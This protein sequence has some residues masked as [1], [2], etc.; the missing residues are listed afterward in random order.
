M[1]KCLFVLSIDTEE[2]WDWNGP[3]PNEVISVENVAE[4]PEF[5]NGLNKLGIIPTYLLD[6]AVIDNSKARNTL[7]T[8]QQQNPE[9]EFGAHLHPWVTPPI[10]N[11][12]AEADS[13][14]VNL[15]IETVQLQIDTLKNSIT[16]YFGR[17]PTSFRSGRWGINNQI[18]SYLLDSGFTVDSSVYPFYKNKWFNYQ[19]TS[20]FPGFLYPKENREESIFELPVT[21]GFNYKNFGFANAAQQFLEKKPMNYLRPIGL[22]WQ[23][24]L[25]RKIYLSPELS[26]ATDMI[27]LCKKAMAINAPVIHMN[28]HS[29][30]LLPG[31]TSYVKDRNEKLKMIEKI[32]R[33]VEYLNDHCELTMCTVSQ[34]AEKLA[35][36]SKEKTDA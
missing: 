10:V 22:L 30:S 24:G 19:N 2:E 14:I 23:L 3:F 20:L 16:E 9:I 25:L 18:L 12:L 17:A 27:T 21:A 34:A 36:N 33:V 1:Y 7:Q 32:S 6:Y 8:V 35:P 28:L 26:T 11:T 13:H 31:A 15:P 29:S 5:Q 4:I